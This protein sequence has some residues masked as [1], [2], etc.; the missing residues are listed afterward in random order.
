MLRAEHLCVNRS[1]RAI[2][3]EVSLAV[4]C[5]AL[6]AVI[7]PNGA[8]KSTLLRALSGELQPAGGHVLLGGRPLAKWSPRQLAQRRAV[9]SQQC[10]L[11]FPLSALEVVLLGRTPH[12]P[13]ESKALARLT[14][15]LIARA[16]LELVGLGARLHDSY[17]T[18]SGGQ[19][20]L[21]HLARVLAQIW[22]PAEDGVR[23]LLLDEP[24]ASLDLRSQHLVL[25][26]ARRLAREGAAVLA[27]LHDVNLA[28]QYA[29]AL[30]VLQDGR[31]VEQ[32]TARRVLQPALLAELFGVP[33]T[34]YGPPER[35]VVVP[36]L[37]DAPR[38]NPES[39][40][41]SEVSDAPINARNP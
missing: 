17:D 7:G 4:P 39:R 14:D 11:A 2:L 15:Q 16:A 18:L 30:I 13:V 19:M 6:V 23:C 37:A 5:G 12:P 3:H 9:L 25:A 22:E 32:G 24:T 1:G 40:S 20:Q 10:S 38:S 21:C 36:I 35:P 27:V 34:L 28:A 31:V 8:G 26:R 29:D 33:V 41:A